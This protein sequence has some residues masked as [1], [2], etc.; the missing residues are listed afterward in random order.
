MDDMRDIEIRVL[1]EV[2]DAVERMLE[3][4]EAAGGAIGMP[5]SEVYAI[6][7][8]AVIA[9]ARADG[10]YGFGSLVRAPLLDA[11]LAGA[12]VEPWDEAVFTVLMGQLT[13]R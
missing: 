3:E 2:I 9:S 7:I 1:R 12:E 13:S 8:Q 5:R 11:I 10:H 6:V 4:L